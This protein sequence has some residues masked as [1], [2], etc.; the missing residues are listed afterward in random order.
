MQQNASVWK[1]RITSTQ[2]G[3]N[4][5]ANYYW[6]SFY[7]SLSAT[8]FAVLT[9]FATIVAITSWFSISCRNKLP[10][11]VWYH[12]HADNR[13]Y[14]RY[15]TDQI[16]HHKYTIKTLNAHHAYTIFNNLPEFRGNTPGPLK[17]GRSGFIL[18]TEKWE[19]K[20]EGRKKGKRE[21][22]RKERK[23]GKGNVTYSPS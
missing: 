1:T 9:T 8:F 20:W 14:L 11:W 21:G 4:R 12:F 16:F 15:I 13:T 17:L 10:S 5:T 6:Q 7:T 19:T 18:E 2:L 23:R 3:P 22:T